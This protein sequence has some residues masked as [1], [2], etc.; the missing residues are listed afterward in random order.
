[1]QTVEVP[2]E[3]LADKARQINIH[4]LQ[5]FYES[6]LFLSNHFIHDKKK[7]NILLTL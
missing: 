7:K 4:N 1:M 5:P 2:E 6:Q 3:E